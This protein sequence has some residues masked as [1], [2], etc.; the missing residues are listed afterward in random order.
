MLRGLYT[1]AS[2]MLAESMRVDQLAN[3]LANVN[4]N[5]Y[6]R[7]QAVFRTFPQLL[8]SRIGENSTIS[9]PHGEIP[10]PMNRSQ[11]IGQLGTGVQLERIYTNTQPGPLAETGNA[12]DLA[13]VGDGYFVIQTPQGQRLTR[14]GAFQLNSDGILVNYDGYAVMGTA[15]PIQILGQL[16]VQED[17]TVL[18]DGQN[19]DRLLIVDAADLTKQGHNLFTGDPAPAGEYQIRQGF[20]ERS[21]VNSVR[22]MVELI[23]ATRA[24]EANQKAIWAQDET[25]GKAISEV[26]RVV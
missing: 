18:S 6:K 13:I 19:V 21:N 15:G 7:D 14:D 2:G 17:G 26:G 23:E 8:L 12:L 1:S 22:S 24:Y 25:L 10:V 5:G 20:I 11:R 3:D 16:L 9:L 4:T